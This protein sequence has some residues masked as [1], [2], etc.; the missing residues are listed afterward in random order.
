MKNKL[1][2]T[3]V[4]VTVLMAF[5]P[6]AQAQ[7]PMEQ[8]VE[9]G[10]QRAHS[11]SLILA[12]ALK[13]KEGALPRTF[14]NGQLQ[15]IRFDHWVSGFFPGVLWMLYENSGCQDRQLRQWAELYTARVEPA[16]RVTNTHDL[17]FM[18]YCSFGQGYRLTGN[19]HYFDV[20]NEGTQSLLTRW[21]ERLVKL[22]PDRMSVLIM[23][24]DNH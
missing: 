22:G 1:V 24:F 18:L 17:G 9:R 2:L 12:E 10:L 15:T 11:Q 20:I 21:N 3:S 8:V 14:E 16:K 13:D 23:P 19:K 6:S 4:M 5:A 7:E